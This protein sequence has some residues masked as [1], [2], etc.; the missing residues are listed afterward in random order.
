M[1]SMGYM[2]F[3]KTPVEVRRNG[4]WCIFGATFWAQKKPTR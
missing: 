2:G 1:R 3:E 4:V